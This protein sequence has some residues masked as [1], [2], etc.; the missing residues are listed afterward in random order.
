MSDPAA[1]RRDERHVERQAIDD[2]VDR[3]RRR[4]P[5]APADLVAEIIARAH[6]EFDEAKI[7]D[8]VPVLVEH[9]AVNQLRRAS[10]YRSAVAPT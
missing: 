4:F 7:R 3:L 9:A 5:D 1:A 6:K 10:G 2:L 8:F